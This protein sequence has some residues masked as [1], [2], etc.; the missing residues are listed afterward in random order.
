MARRATTA[1][2]KTYGY[3]RNR[4]SKAQ[5]KAKLVGVLYLLGTLAMFFAGAC[6]CAL[7]GAFLS[8][9]DGLKPILQF[10]DEVKTILKGGKV[11]S[12]GVSAINKIILVLYLITLLA[13]L[14]NVIRAFGKLN[15]LFKRRASYANG[16]NR[17]MYAMD[18]LS[19]RFSGS[20]HALIV[21]NLFAYV[22]AE[23]QV[24]ITTY[25]FGILAIGFA[26]HIFCGLMEGKTPLFTT[27]AKVEEEPR[28]FGLF[29]FF[30]RNVLQIVAVIAVLYFFL[31]SSIFCKTLQLIIEKT[32]VA[33]DT[34]WLAEN[35]VTLLPFFI[36]SLTWI[37]IIVLIKHA[38]SATEFNR[39]C[40][41]ADGI[42]NFTIFSF[43]VAVC[44]S[45]IYL[46]PRFGIGEVIAQANG[47][48]I[49][50]CI[51]LVA[52]LL[53]CIV[54]PRRHAGFDDYD[55]L[56]VDAYFNVNSDE[57]KYNNTII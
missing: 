18:D 27:G 51:A 36:E 50:A 37:F 55:E 32:L 11:A 49:S 3:I 45:G 48:L 24:S 20:F 2:S 23:G 1:S 41:D 56:D 42:K 28:E 6:V 54:R 46:L 43:L 13:L 31:P 21:Y 7:D 10:A 22:L 34:A 35:V 17:N 29:T 19:K 38:T 44:L 39:D 25:G 26:I 57:T 52:F 30:L 16:F 47:V 9:K 53:D 4:I 14:I 5:S 33:G 8:T 12:E 15:W 40:L